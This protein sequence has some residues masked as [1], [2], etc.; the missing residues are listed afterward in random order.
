MTARGID[1]LA[2]FVGL[3]REVSDV[4]FEGRDPAL[5]LVK[6]YSTSSRSGLK[7]SAEEAAVCTMMITRW[8]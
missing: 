2:A 5:Q 6:R 7:P 3:V 1:F 4:L 8:E